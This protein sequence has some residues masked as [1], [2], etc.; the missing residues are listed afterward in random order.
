[1]AQR[2]TLA[3]S[4][5]V[6]NIPGIP[7]TFSRNAWLGENKK[8]RQSPKLGVPLRL[9]VRAESSGGGGGGGEQGTSQY[10]LGGPGSFFGFGNFQERLV[11]RFAMVG[12]VAALVM[13]VVTGKGIFGQLGLDPLRVRYPVLLGFTFLLVAGLVGGY[14]VINNP[15]DESKAPPNE[16]AGVPRDPLKTFDPKDMDRLP[17]YT[18]GGV[19]ERPDGQRGREPYVSDLDVKD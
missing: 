10:G 9:T 17:T 19:V 12:V 18:R 4:V 3:S 5:C 2:L 16:G 14:V 1:M 13:E 7:T 11:G 6:A 8:W 15:P